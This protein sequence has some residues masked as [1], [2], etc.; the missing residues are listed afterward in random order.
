MKEFKYILVL[1]LFICFSVSSQTREQGP[2]WPHPI[3]GA[4]DQKG[5][6][7]WI[8]NEKVLS[9]F[10]YVKTGEVYELGRLYEQGMPLSGERTYA[11]HIPSFPTHGPV[12][13]EK[14]VFNDE[15]IATEIGQV[16][17]QFDGLGH[18][19]KQIT[20]ADG[21]V[22]EV[23]YNGYSTADMKN[24]YGLLKLGIEHVKPIITK[25]LLIDITGYKNLEAVPDAYEITIADVLGALAKQG[26]SENSL[27]P[28][29]AL[30]FN[31]GWWRHWPEDFVMDGK[32]RPRVNMD[33]V[34]WI[35][36][37]KPSMVGSDLIMDGEI[38]NVHTE[39]TMKNGIFNLEF[40]NFEK[41]AADKAYEF[42]FIFTP[43]KFKGAT[44]SPG[45]P[46]AIR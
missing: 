12:G 32:R 11:F 36:D 6:S 42:L 1:S 2:W 19:G 25:G 33:V 21:S 37:K 14:V 5:A 38:F 18:P 4:A 20:M 17:T 45:S 10:Q 26:I 39:L 29:D 24:A 9:A 7:N 8:T 23:F 30:L 31:F 28:G 22:T 43:V 40:M 27:L 44:G 41:L 13:E 16:G 46:I 15:Y 3:W 34:N 35:I